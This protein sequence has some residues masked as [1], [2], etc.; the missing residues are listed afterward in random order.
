MDNNISLFSCKCQTKTVKTFKNRNGQYLKYGMTQA[1]TNLWHGISLLP[2]CR[3]GKTTW[4]KTN[5]F[6][7]ET[8]CLG[9]YKKK[10]VGPTD[11]PSMWRRTV[12][13][14]HKSVWESYGILS[15]PHVPQTRR[16][17][18]AHTRPSTACFRVA[19]PWTWAAWHG[20]APHP[21]VP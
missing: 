11:P 8:F 12:L 1:S 16:N 20:L 17:R 5:N 2:T 9:V 14:P 3:S 18:L 21:L 4:S 7:C 6:Y 19:S 15:R 13:P 10:G